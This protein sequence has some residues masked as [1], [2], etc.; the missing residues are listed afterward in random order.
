MSYP[1]YL[2]QQSSECVRL[3]VEGA[4]RG[5]ADA[6]IDLAQHYSSWAT[7]VEHQ[8]PSVHHIA[9]TELDGDGPASA[10]RRLFGWLHK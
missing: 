5:R 6:L 2:R 4:G 8:P 3:A 1:Q 9:R 10:G 7:A